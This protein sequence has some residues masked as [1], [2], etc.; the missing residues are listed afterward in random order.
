MRPTSGTRVSWAPKSTGPLRATGLLFTL[1]WAPLCADYARELARRLSRR[2]VAEKSR[3]RAPAPLVV[4]MK[5]PQHGISPFE[6][7]ARAKF[8]AVCAAAL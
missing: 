1:D 7:A 8:R 6:Q 5:R 2:I 3:G 4:L